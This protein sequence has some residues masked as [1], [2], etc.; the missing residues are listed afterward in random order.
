LESLDNKE[1][2]HLPKQLSDEERTEM[3]K[4]IFK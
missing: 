2:Y 3:L 4:N 1:E